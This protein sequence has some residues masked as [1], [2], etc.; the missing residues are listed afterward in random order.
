MNRNSQPL[1][2]SFLSRIHAILGENLE[3]TELNS[4]YSL[5][6]LLP[7]GFTLSMNAEDNP[8]IHVPLIH[9]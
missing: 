2:Q 9:C 4:L 1:R 8:V 5:S 6:R 7:A 3:K